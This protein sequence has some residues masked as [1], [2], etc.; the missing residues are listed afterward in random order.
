MIR[1]TQTSRESNISGFVDRVERN[2]SVKHETTL[3]RHVHAPIL[4]H[5]PQVE[6]INNLV[7]VH[8]LI[9]EYA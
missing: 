7:V 6:D 3:Y 9:E 8:D 4:V 1:I 5:K 2:Y